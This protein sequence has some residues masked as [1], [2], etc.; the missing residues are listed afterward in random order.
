MLIKPTKIA[1]IQDI[2]GVGLRDSY[3]EKL[4]NFQPD[5]LSFAEYFLVGPEYTNT[6][7]AS[8][9]R[10]DHLNQIKAWSIDFN[11]LV[12]GG[13]IVDGENGKNFNRCYLVDKGSVIGSYDKIHLYRNE[14][15]EQITPGHEHKVFQ[16]RDIKIGLL[17][18]ADVLYPESFQVLRELKPDLIFIPTTSPYKAGEKPEEK[19]MRDIEIF[20]N[21]AAEADAILFK[22]SAIGTIIGHPLQGRSLIASP[23]KIH[24]RID[25]T[26]EDKPALILA[27]LSGDKHNPSLDIIVHRD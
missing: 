9:M 24:W 19:F 22:V 12:V 20:A 16:W 23:D 8:V 10:V 2:P 27:A 4:R 15:G 5:I 25:P 1:M 14:G 6:A 13:T 26:D 3:R 17:I 11:C 21:G 7:S 18:C